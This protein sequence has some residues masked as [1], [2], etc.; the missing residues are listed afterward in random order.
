MKRGVDG[1][2]SPSHLFCTG[3][4]NMRFKK[5]IYNIAFVLY[6]WL[7]KNPSG[8]K[9]RILDFSFDPWKTVFSSTIYTHTFPTLVI[10][11][12][13]KAI[14]YGVWQPELNY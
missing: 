13:G 11:L 14:C 6:Q 3:E 1:P 9:V 5:K 8:K 4:Q 12:S 10:H 2:N 7:K